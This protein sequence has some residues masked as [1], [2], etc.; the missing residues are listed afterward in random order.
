VSDHQ[1]HSQLVY[2]TYALLR[3]SQQWWNFS[4][5]KLAWKTLL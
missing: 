1:R 4:C 2:F 5:V 3:Q